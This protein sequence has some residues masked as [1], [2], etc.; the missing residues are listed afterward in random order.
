MLICHYC[1]HEAHGKCASCGLAVCPAHG[2]RYCCV[3]SNAVFAVE[4]PE[5]PFGRQFLQCPPKPQMQTI[6]LD[7]DGPPEC[8]ACQGIAR[9]VC[10]NCHNLFCKEHG[11]DGWCDE[12]TK[13]ARVGTWLTAG[14]VAAMFILA[15]VIYLVG[16]HL[17]Q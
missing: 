2:G 16:S 13:Q 3:C 8:Y 12:C 14:I 7:D 6:Y 5:D 1:N 9:K 15:G 10:Q 11:K 17:P 4:K